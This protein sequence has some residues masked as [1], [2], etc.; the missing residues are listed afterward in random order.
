MISAT[1]SSALPEWRQ[2][3]AVAG[4]A[5]QVTPVETALTHC[6]ERGSAR[7]TTDRETIEEYYAQSDKAHQY[8]RDWGY[9]NAVAAAYWRMRDALVLNAITAH[10]D[11][12]KEPLRVL[13]VGTG[14]GH[15]LAKFSLLGI[16]AGFLSGVDIVAD[17]VCRARA[18]YPGIDFSRQDAM[19]L[20]F[21]DN[22]FDIV[23]QFTCVMHALTDESQRA[24]CREMSRVLKSGGIIIWWDL[25]PP[26]WKLVV[27]RRLCRALRRRSFRECW[28]SFGK[29]FAEIWL[30]RRRNEALDVAVPPYMR[31][32]DERRLKEL[33]IGLNVRA[34][35]AGLDYPVWDLLWRRLPSLAEFLWRRAWLSQHCFAVVEKV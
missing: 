22:T 27:C 15:E 29:A 1:P 7:S 35:L 25:V 12:L 5:P 3:E 17:R 4:P 20:S 31:P 18:I 32:I 23:C 34:R 10:F 30:P 26:R 21:R 11:P 16:P 9:V 28:S 6:R 24:I 19:H 14:H 2:G 13:E 8:E 33:F